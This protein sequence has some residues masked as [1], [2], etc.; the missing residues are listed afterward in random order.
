MFWQ[1]RTG[2]AC[3][4]AALSGPKPAPGDVRR[5]NYRESEGVQATI[6][7]VLFEAWNAF[8]KLKCIKERLNIEGKKS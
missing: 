8:E 6:G 7:R 2:R 3:K 5:S 1:S 4:K